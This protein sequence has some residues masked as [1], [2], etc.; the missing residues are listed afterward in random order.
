MDTLQILC[1]F[2]REFQFTVM[3]Q[4]LA[5]HLILLVAIALRMCFCGVIGS[6]DLLLHLSRNH[7][8]FFAELLLFARA[9]SKPGAIITYVE[10]SSPLKREYL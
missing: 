4:K 5:G 10:S 7:A 8:R 6:P 2:D 1:I 3:F 9:S